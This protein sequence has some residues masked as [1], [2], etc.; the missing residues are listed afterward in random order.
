MARLIW[1][2]VAALAATRGMA[3]GL[4][5][6][7]DALGRSIRQF[8]HVRSLP[9]AD[10]A[11]L[12]ERA[13]GGRYERMLLEAQR[14]EQDGRWERTIELYQRLLDE[15]SEELVA[16]SPRLLLPMRTVVEERLG[17]LPGD[18][19]AAYR[20]R[21]DPR[22]RPLFEAAVRRSREAALAEV[23]RRFLLSSVGDD[24][25]DRLAT[26]WLARGQAGRAL[27]AWRRLLRVY[28]DSDL[29]P[30]SVAAKLAAALA[31]LG[32]VAE[33]RK[34][35]QN[36]AERLPGATVAAG[37]QKMSLEAFARKL[38]D[39]SAPDRTGEWW[40]TEG[41]GTS[42]S[43]R[44][45]RPLRPGSL[46]W[47]DAIYPQEVARALSAWRGSRTFARSRY[48]SEPPVRVLPILAAGKVVYP[49]RVGLLAR[50][51]VTGKLSWE[52]PWPA[53]DA[54]WGSVGVFG[55]GGRFV[56]HW[57][58]SSDGASVFC[59]IPRLTATRGRLTAMRGE[60]AAVDLRT[61]RTRWV[62]SVSELVPP[63]GRGAGWFVSPPLPTDGVLV[64]GVRRGPRGG[65]YY[66]CG[67]DPDGQPL[68]QR[69]VSARDD[70]PAALL[71]EDQPW[72][73]GMAAAG[74]GLAVACAGGGVVIAV[75]AAS[76][77]VRWLTRY[78]QVGRAFFRLRYLSARR[79]RSSTPA[80][81][82]GIVYVTP[83]DSDFI[84]ALDLESGRTLW[85]RERGSYSYLAGAVDGKV[86]LS[87][88]SACCIA[89]DGS[90][91]WERELPSRVV[92]RP[93]VAGHV[94][95]LPLPG[96]LLY[97]DT[98]TGAELGRT[99]WES[100]RAAH[101]PTWSADVASGDL[102]AG[103]GR[104]IVATPH[105]INAYEPDDARAAL[106]RLATARPDDPAV[107]LALGKE[108]QWEGD[109]A[110]ASEE[111][112]KA[113]ARRERLA[114]GDV[115][116]LRRRLATCYD[117]VARAH[118]REGRPG[119]ALSALEA[120]LRHAS[121]GPQRSNLLLRLGDL[122]ARLK[123]WK[124]AVGA[125][126]DVLA[127]NPPRSSARESARARLEAV[128]EAAGRGPYGEFDRAADEALRRGDLPVVLARYPNSL[129]APKA[130]WSLA[131]AAQAKGRKDEA[132]LRLGEL[133]RVYPASPL[134]P[135]AL[136]ELAIGY[137]K[138]RAA[139]M[140]LG[141]LEALDRRYARWAREG[142][143]KTLATRSTVRR[144]LRER[145]RTTPPELAPMLKVRWQCKP[146]YGSREVVVLPTWEGGK[147]RLFTVA[148]RSFECREPSGGSL[149]WADRPGWIGVMIQD[150]MRPE[151]GVL[152]TGTVRGL[153]QSPAEKAGL[154]AGDILVAFDG[155]PLRD[156]DG[157]ISACA[158]RRAGAVVKLEFLREGERRVVELR[159]GERPNLPRDSILP[160]V[161][162]V[163]FASGCA[164]VL[165]GS[166]LVALAA[167]DGQVRWS[168]PL[169]GSGA[170]KVAAG[171]ALVVVAD[172]AGRLRALDAATGSRLW[173]ANLPEPTVHD[174][175]L[176][177]LGL[178]VVSS[179]PAT[180]RLVNPFDGA[181][182]AKVAEPRAFGR[183]LVALDTSGRVCYAMGGRLGCLDA[184]RRRLLWAVRVP[185]LSA[186]RLWVNSG[187]VVVQG[188]DGRGS[189][190]LECRRAEDGAAVW[191]VTL[192]RGEG[193]SHGWLGELGFF[194]AS[195]AGA[196]ALV[197]RL[198]AATGKVAW[199]RQLQ[200]H[201]ELGGWVAGRRALVL[202]VST[203]GAEGG[204]VAE[205]A[206]LDL[207]TGEQVQRLGLGSGSLVG[208]VRCGVSLYAVVEDA[209]GELRPR[210]WLGDVFA[211][212]PPRFRVVRLTAGEPSRPGDSQ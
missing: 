78:D 120:A 189:D 173:E 35:L 82:D 153:P 187:S 190:V 68:W 75:E 161:R 20:R 179:R 97:L 127:S 40:P 191:S 126:Q 132:R 170:E 47:A 50:D 87:G 14:A 102:V 123:R 67:L 3:G 36:L 119:L 11:S 80:I 64:V 156:T 51:V 66:L 54:D 42:Q 198:D 72:F 200:P 205:L 41:G 177:D 76:G 175:R 197:R 37:G 164:L 22:A 115:A 131:R 53:G 10:L 19:L 211:P 129:A 56:G 26:R 16:V 13:S 182:L 12:T 48:S 195:R 184:S 38:G 201:E 139:A 111:F 114:E 147:E 116:D 121:R 52:W 181:E 63:E 178:V 57:A 49:C 21:G 96:G 95:Y 100:W 94:L 107:H 60:L 188:R 105:T 141:T 193:F 25:L 15:A 158:L 185:D 160:E 7:R 108:Y 206:V 24:A 59:S 90:L 128:I 74:D 84:Y 143:G 32:R 71:Y 33:A 146:E 81:C 86:F 145:R 5:A 103:G 174:L 134:A 104:L 109:V 208:L 130:L 2:L 207:A 88:D 30:G 166:S 39:A 44:A 99:L 172:G 135:R 138:D 137:A 203:V 125:F 149:R 4:G 43:R 133:A 46:A 29:S 98:A 212:E 183:P 124:E 118:E 196:R 136:H 23:A 167:E 165:K 117:Y 58:P 85:R 210:A 73:E 61:G 34:L 168:L 113:I 194:V 77:Q 199:S 18:G 6:V 89:A 70:D 1:F 110:R 157:L 83:L 151:G 204:R 62:R 28:P 142:E 148:G 91:E 150:A 176:S 55:V 171:P 163:G 154:R 209:L 9:L 112:E 155:K 69:F 79:W 106:E 92:G 65:E 27:R 140:A 202:G 162:S 180:V 93:L 159:L 186:E 45:G 101:G 17:N 152:I 31:R 122:A 144:L 169:D 8:R 192:G